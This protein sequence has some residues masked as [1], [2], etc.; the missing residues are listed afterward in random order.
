M[1]P[2]LLQFSI[3]ER[4]LIGIKKNCNNWKKGGWGILIRGRENSKEIELERYYKCDKSL[5]ACIPLDIYNILILIKLNTHC[6]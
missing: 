1:T 3:L 5:S 6:Y 4:K 2:P